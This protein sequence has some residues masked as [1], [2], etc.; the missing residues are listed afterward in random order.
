MKKFTWVITGSIYIPLTE[1]SVPLDHVKLIGTNL[2]GVAILEIL[3]SAG[4]IDVLRTNS[5]D[6]DVE[7]DKLLIDPNYYKYS[8]NVLVEILSNMGHEVS[9][10]H[11][12]RRREKLIKEGKSK[13]LPREDRINMTQYNAQKKLTNNQ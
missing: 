10:G 5:D 2:E 1:D 3:K 9:R 11:V 13:Y 6:R 12:Y 7:L 4:K 8:D